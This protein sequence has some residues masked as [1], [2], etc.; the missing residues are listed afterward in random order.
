MT[1]TNHDTAL[2][3]ALHQ[4]AD[5]IE[6]RPLL[7][8][9]LAAARCGE[10]A[11]IALITLTKLAALIAALV[12]LTQQDPATPPPTPATRLQENR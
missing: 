12:L 1:T 6:P 10:P 2:H 4:H 8:D 11:L 3:K 5:H 7:P 9:I